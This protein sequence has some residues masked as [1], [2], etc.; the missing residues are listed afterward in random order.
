MALSYIVDTS[1]Y[2]ALNRGEQRLSDYFKSS[3]GIALPT[4]VI[5]ELRAGFGVGS[6]QKQ[7]ESLLQ[8]FLDAPNVN[9][10]TLSDTT[11]RTFA[12]I[13][14][15]LRGAGTPV[16]TNDMWIAAL[17]LEHNLPVL[18]LDRHFSCIDDLQLCPL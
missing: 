12:Q 8:R 2:S 9:L 11:T 6:K 16:G 15:T 17:A 13:Y 5:G 4:I 10:I 3:H 18:T 14:A 1:A 7:N